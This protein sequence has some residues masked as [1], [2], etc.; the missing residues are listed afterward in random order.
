[1]QL[2]AL[3]DKAAEALLA[4]DLAA[5]ARLAPGI[6]AARIAP[7]DRESAE[8]LQRKAQRNARLLDA[9]ARGV[10][11]AR[12]R[13]TEISRGPMLTT[14]DARGQRAEIAPPGGAPAR[15]V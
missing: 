14:Y 2:E 9:A 4:G 1:M 10:K 15:R 12:L 11:A 3:L 6:E 5:L 8:R 13:M 7:T